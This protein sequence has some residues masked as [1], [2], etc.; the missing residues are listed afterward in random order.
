MKLRLQ[1]MQKALGQRFNWPALALT[2]R[3]LA[4]GQS[5]LMIPHLE[6]PSLANLDLEALKRAG[7]TGLVLDKD[8]TPTRPY[9]PRPEPEQAE[10]LA[11]AT[12][13]FG[14]QRVVLLSNSAGGPDDLGY[15]EADALERSLGI[16][17]LR[18][19]QRK[20]RCLDSVTAHFGVADCS[21]LA[22]VGDR[23][24]T[25][26]SFGNLHGMLTVRSSPLTMSGEPLV[27]RCARFVERWLARLLRA[28][29]VRAP[30]HVLERHLRLATP[31]AAPCVR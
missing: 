26:V 13:L 15:E 22:M 31:R 24:L 25:D 17:V 6:A 28:R 14:A 27:V 1:L 9:E 18:H 20:P 29:G 11:R 23:Y 5:T 10:A 8:T 21:S 30:H 12:A 3:I 16:P 19:A 2:A 4:G 7:I